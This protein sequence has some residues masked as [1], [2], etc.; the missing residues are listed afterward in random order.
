MPSSD[1]DD[2]DLETILSEIRFG[3]QS[4]QEPGG[5]P[6]DSPRP[7]RIRD[8]VLYLRNLINSESNRSNV[9]DTIRALETL[10]QEIEEHHLDQIRDRTNFEQ[11]RATVD[12]QIQQLQSDPVDGF[13]R[14]LL[15]AHRLPSASANPE[16]RPPNNRT[17]RRR[18][19]RP[20]LRESLPTPSLMPQPS[21]NGRARLKRRKLDSDDNREGVRGFNYGQYG[22]VV[23]GPLKMEIASCDG[24]NYD[25]DGDM[26]NVLRNDQSV[27][28]TKS[29]RCNLVL[30]H[31]GEAPF[32]LKKIVIKA[33]EIGFDSPYVAASSLSGFKFLT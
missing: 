22:Q 26:E 2:P 18:S 16:S 3:S 12:R 11:A 7:P 21:Q 14:H 4:S 32:C 10:N 28:C 20:D 24:G 19:F 25:P 6:R 9:D 29:D 8:R 17:L 5:S 1:P 15:E 30:R 31:R 13:R 23:P 27:Y 33:P